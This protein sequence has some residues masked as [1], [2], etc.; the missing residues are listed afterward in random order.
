MTIVIAIIRAAHHW[1]APLGD[2]ARE[3]RPT[4]RPACHA[5]AGKD[6]THSIE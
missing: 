1:F 4:V 3:Y 2:G 6:E 5:S